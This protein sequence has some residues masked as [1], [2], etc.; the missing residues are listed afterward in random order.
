MTLRN[1]RHKARMISRRGRQIQSGAGTSHRDTVIQKK[2][3]LLFRSVPIENV[4]GIVS[5]GLANLNI[6]TD[7]G[8]ATA[9]QQPAY[10]AL[11]TEAAR[12]Y[13]QYRIRRVVIRA[14]PGLGFTNDMRIKT[15]VFARVDVDSGLFPVTE[16]SVLSLMNT[17][18]TVNKTFTERS[19]IKLCDYQPICFPTGTINSTPI[20][21]NNLNWYNIDERRTHSWRGVVVAPVIPDNTILPNTTAIT[22]WADV[23]MEFRGRSPDND[24]FANIPNPLFPLLEEVPKDDY[25]SSERSSCNDEDRC[26][27]HE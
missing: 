19:N 22:I 13:E 2:K 25:E 20:L 18:A 21:P 5:Y 17:E 4:S 23:E 6:T 11:M 27:D 14:Q 24:V 7:A 10:E 1:N 12:T 8:S 3:Y 15:S 16:D 26:T 9:I